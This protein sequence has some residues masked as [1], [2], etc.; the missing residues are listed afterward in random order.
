MLL[1]FPR[2]ESLDYCDMTS[3]ALDSKQS[4]PVDKLVSK[5][6][7]EIQKTLQDFRWKGEFKAQRDKMFKIQT[8]LIKRKNE[9]KTLGG[10][11][12]GNRKMLAEF[13]SRIRQIRETLDLYKEKVDNQVF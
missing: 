10:M 9:K 1:K 13:N 2:L 5:K 6:V 4:E 8:L 12:A 3:K 11:A 7:E